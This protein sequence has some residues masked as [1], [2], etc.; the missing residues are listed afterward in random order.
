MTPANPDP[1]M[2]VFENQ[3]HSVTQVVDSA[4]GRVDRV[5]TG[6]ETVSLNTVTGER[7]FT[8]TTTV[9]RTLDGRTAAPNETYVCRQCRTGPW[10]VSAVAYCNRC[11][12]VLCKACAGNP[13][14]CRGCRWRW[15]LRRFFVWV[16]NL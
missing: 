8:A 6:G 12:K 5:P 15:Y 9:L 3:Q 1:R 4:D 13:A 10:S 11:Q 16:S 14:Y 7:V 2:V